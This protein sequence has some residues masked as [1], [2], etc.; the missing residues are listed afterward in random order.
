MLW[1]LHGCGR[2]SR[3]VV[4][5]PDA[6]V[7]GV[8]SRLVL[9]DAGGPKLVD[10]IRVVQ[11]LGSGL[12]EKLRAGP[13]KIGGVAMDGSMTVVLS[14]M[15]RVVSDCSKVSGSRRTGPW[16]SSRLDPACHDDPLIVFSPSIGTI[17]S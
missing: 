5:H 1:Y 10:G 14:P 7:V 4:T 17:F 8:V 3:T 11:S 13:V 15:L 2:I 16:K 6:V 12:A 9:E